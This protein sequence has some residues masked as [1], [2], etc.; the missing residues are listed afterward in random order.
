MSVYENEK[1]TFLLHSINSIQ[2]QTVYPNEIVIVKD[3]P[4]TKEL[5]AI[6]ESLKDD[7]FKIV[8]LKENV[9]LGKALNI[10]LGN[11]TNN[12]VAR[13]DSDDI[14][15]S[16][17]F[18]KQLKYLNQN[19]HV[20]V[21]GTDVIE[22]EDGPPYKEY[23]K[24]LPHTREEIEKYSIMRNPI[25]HPSVM[26]RKDRVQEA[27]GY[28]DC[29]LFEDYYLWIR[30]LKNGSVIEN[31][32]EPLIY[33]RAGFDMYARRGGWIYVKRVIDFRKKA[34]KIKFNSISQAIISAVPQIVI[35]ILPKALRS[36]FYKRILRIQKVGE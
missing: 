6:I 18:E 32:D 25:C 24:T 31:L 4:L 5:E 13:M 16:T 21:L 1:P 19:P 17:R 10:G 27:G 34:F 23:V 20:D 8:A 29:L 15:V 12:I 2:N 26:L 28:Q 33:M 36:L 7:R 35:A 14:S 30:L 9:G 3:G 22:F 11:C